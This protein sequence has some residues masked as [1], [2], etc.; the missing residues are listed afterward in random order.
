[1][2]AVQ[3]Q[4]PGSGLHVLVRM[5]EQK[6]KVQFDRSC[7]FCSYLYLNNQLRE[8]CI[9]PFVRLINS[10]IYLFSCDSSG[11]GRTRI[12]RVAHSLAH[13]GR[14][15][16]CVGIR[17]FGKFDG[18]VAGARTG[19]RRGRKRGAPVILRCRP[20]RSVISDGGL[21]SSKCGGWKG[22]RPV[23]PLRWAESR[24]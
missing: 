13:A 6:I 24:R 11:D 15:V 19:A 20:L 2:A 7:W 23:Y 21:G 16:Y 18:G 1:M 12:H 17:Q 22:T 4:L 3:Q 5:S 8:A 10:C 9:D 14:G